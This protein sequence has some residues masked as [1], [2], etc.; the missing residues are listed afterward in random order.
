MKNYKARINELIGQMT[1]REKIAQLSQTVAGYRCF[2]RDGENFYLVDEFKKFVKEYGAM[3]ALSNIL[4]ADV[5]TKHDWGQGIE[6]RHRVKFANALQKY[7]MDNSRIGIPVLIEVESNHG[8]QALGSTMFPTNIGIGSSFNNELYADI[9]ETVGKEIS[10]SG[11]HMG[12]VTMLDIAR[13][14]R[15]GRCEELFSEDPYLAGEFAK[16]GVEGFKRQGPLVCCKHFCGAGDGF[17]GINTAEVNVGVRELH[18]IHLPAA[19]KA[20]KAGADVF[21]AAYNTIDGIPCHVNPYILKTVLRDELGFEGIVL[22]DG[23]AVPRAIKQMGYDPVTGAARVLNSG[24]DLS[25]A[26]D[27]AYLK[28]EDALKEGLVEERTIDE[29]VSRIL[30]KKFEIGLMDNPYLPEDDALTVYLNS[31]VQ[32]EL[33]YRAAS[34]SAVLLKNNGVLPISTDKKVALIGAHADNIYYQLGDY[35]AYAKSGL[36]TI[37]NVFEEGFANTEFTLGWDFGKS[38]DDFDNAL[39]IAKESDIVVVTLGGNSA[40]NSARVKLDPATGAAISADSFLDCGEGMDMSS[41]SLPGNQVKLVEKLCELGKP[42]IALLIEGRPYEITRVNEIADA[43]LTAW[44]PGDEGAEAIFDILTGKVNPSGKLSISIPYAPTCLPAYY[45]RIAPAEVSVSRSW[46]S[47]TYSDTPQRV[48]YPFGYGLS[49]SKFEYKAMD[50]K[51]TEKNVFEVSVT[52]KN[53][54]EIPGKEAVQLYIHGSGNSVRRRVRELKGFKKIHLDA[55]EEKTVKFTLGYDE[56]KVFSINNKFELEA[57]NVD[58]YAGSGD[59]LPLRGK[60]SVVL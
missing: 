41:I 51:E 25:L 8:L 19:E 40:R 15:W 37:R 27:S 43:V 60:F 46:T 1:V 31:G 13:D 58:V 2:T 57:C 55:G 38:E 20:V 17:G 30:E 48:L 52:V 24:V 5:F 4:R 6:P 28:L 59:D 34:E 22:S 36:K 14:P 21:M 7:V 32:K 44:Y 42:V 12:F 47:N 3:G 53:V 29:A 11:N 33:A 35:S 26:D 50:I 56:L 18:D 23:W 39:R 45:N 54:S 16:S 49:Y 10:L 9:M